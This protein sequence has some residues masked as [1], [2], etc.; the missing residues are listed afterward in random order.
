MNTVHYSNMVHV[1]TKKEKKSLLNKREILKTSLKLLV[2]EGFESFSMHKLAKK[3]DWAV[4][5]AYRYY[6]SKN[7]LFFELEKRVIEDYGNVIIRAKD[8]K[9]KRS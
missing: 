4:G 6:P 7:L 1:F 2:E 8:S 3:L 5:T 9:G